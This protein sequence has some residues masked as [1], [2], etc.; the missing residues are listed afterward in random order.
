MIVDL[1]G[2]ALNLVCVLFDCIVE[3]GLVET[4]VAV[5]VCAERASV[6]LG[7]RLELRGGL[8]VGLARLALIRRW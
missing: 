7:L 2:G 3:V 6:S 4:L 1:H 5:I 8:F